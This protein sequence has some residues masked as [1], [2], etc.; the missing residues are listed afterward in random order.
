MAEEHADLCW[1]MLSKILLLVFFIKKL[2][3]FV[4]AQD[5]NLYVCLNNGN[6]TVNSTYSR[7]LNTLLSS[8]SSNIADNGFYNASVGRNLDTANALVLC[9]TDRTLDQCRTCVQNAAV[10]VLDVCPNQRQAVIWYEFCML[11][12]SNEPIYG[13]PAFDPGYN[14]RNTLDVSS[15]VDRFRE[16]RT[17]LLADLL[18]QAANGSSAV[19]GGAGSR[20]TSNS[21]T[22]YGLVQCTPDLSPEDCYDCLN[23]AVQPIEV[24]TARGMRILMPSCNIRYELYS[25]YNETRLREIQV[26][27]PPPLPPPPSPPAGMNNDTTGGN[28]TNNDSTRG[29]KDDN[30]TKIVISIVVP[31]VVCLIVAAFAV[32]CVR[33]RMK[34]RP[35]RI[36]TDE[37]NDD[38]S[39]VESLQHDFGK[40]RD[41]TND[42]DDA[43]KLGQG[44]FGAVYMGRLRNGEE[45]AVKRLSKD[46]GQGNVEFK[47][48]VLLVAKLQHRNLVRLLGFSIEGTERLLIYEYVENAS[49]DQFIFDP[50]KRSILDW[51][52]RYKIIGGIA[53]GLVYLH[54][55]SRLRIIHRDLK[56]SNILLD[57]EMNPKI[58]DFGMAR[59]FGQDETQGNTSKIVGT[60]GYMS[61]EYAMH[62]HFSVKS[63]V[64]SFGVLVLEIMSGQKNN[65]IRNGDNVEDLL[66]FTWKNWREGTAENIIDPV[67]RTAGTGSLRDMIKCIHIGLLCVQENAAS[68]P[69]MASILV[70]LSSST[71]TLPVPSEPAFFMASR[72]GPDTLHLRNYDDSNSSDAGKG[73][74]ARTAMSE[75]SSVNDVT[76]TELDP[77]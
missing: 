69:T 54:E 67:L 9:R 49:L 61:P 27:L 26:L 22:L 47:N 12:Y 39:T 2:S 42:F 5:Q 29:K 63:D 20:N 35:Q 41:A 53:R 4:G 37:D 59:L 70:M 60:Y 76:V 71:M 24:S 51:D 57:G 14:L 18:T 21:E 64:F 36:P 3:S 8:L 11:R 74:K 7:N 34:R 44:G 56:A 23:R 48:E 72:F 73:M 13:T 38:I 32:I 30:T 10:G 16:N 65:S 77:R 33:K 28:G 43:N 55:D 58:A 1:K 40:I 62:G 68:R 45:I 50:V 25:F 75:G 19:K 15:S 66:T 31:V 46:S 17:R 6:Y 52:K